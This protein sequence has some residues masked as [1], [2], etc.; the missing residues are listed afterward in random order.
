MK[1]GCCSDS[2]GLP[3]AETWIGSTSGNKGKE[4]ELTL[5][6]LTLQTLGLGAARRAPPHSCDSSAQGGQRHAAA[7]QGSQKPRPQD[8][9]SRT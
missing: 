9:S 3:L 7:R 8:C 1:E 5:G 6:E 4:A 2:P